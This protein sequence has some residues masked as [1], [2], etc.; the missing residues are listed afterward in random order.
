MIRSSVVNEPLITAIVSY[1][2][3]ALLA[4]YKDVV[5]FIDPELKDKYLSVTKDKD[6]EEKYS[7]KSPWSIQRIQ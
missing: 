6:K 3:K 4:F 5:F 7:L 2:N 1:T